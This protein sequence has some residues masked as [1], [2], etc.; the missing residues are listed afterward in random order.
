MNILKHLRQKLSNRFQFLE[1][2]RVQKKQIEAIIAKY[3]LNDANE[4]KKIID[5]YLLSQKSK[6]AFGR[7]EKLHIEEKIDFMIHYNL[8]K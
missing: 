1:K 7:K 5:N 6:R 3:K 4:Q 8:L 2:K